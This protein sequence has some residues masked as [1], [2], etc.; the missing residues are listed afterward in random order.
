[1]SIQ[2]DVTIFK[3]SMMLQN[4]LYNVKSNVIKAEF[5][6]LFLPKLNTV[7]LRGDSNNY[8]QY[9]IFNTEKKIILNYPRYGIF[10][11]GLKNEFEIAVVYEPS[12][13]EPL[14]FYCTVYRQ[15]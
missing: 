5:P 7:E 3:F 6:C 12:V 11:K 8:T 13:F 14:K 9:T 1:M 15:S 4:I 10:S 2:F